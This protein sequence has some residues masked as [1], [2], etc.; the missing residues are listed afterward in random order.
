MVYSL[1]LMPVA[2]LP[3]MT[4]LASVVYAAGTSIL[5]AAYLGSSIA[6]MFVENRKRARLLLAVSLIYLPLQFALVFLDP[7]VRQM[8][9]SI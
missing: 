8:L 2:L 1:F 6:F 4:G 5:C 3:A 7:S 9:E